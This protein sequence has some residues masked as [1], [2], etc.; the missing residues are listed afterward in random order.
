MN[1][2]LRFIVAAALLGGNPVLAA[3]AQMTAT[4]SVVGACAA[5]APASIPVANKAPPGTY[6]NVNCSSGT[7]YS[8]GYGSATGSATGIPASGVPET[9]NGLITVTY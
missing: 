7:A 2:R 1:Q 5:T 8:V 6:L 4:V 9:A 3:T